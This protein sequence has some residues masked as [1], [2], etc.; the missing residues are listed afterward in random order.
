MPNK[1]AQ[2]SGLNI[3]LLH[4]F[5]VLQVWHSARTPAAAQTTLGTSS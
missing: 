1:W 5:G 4:A 3:N 2:L